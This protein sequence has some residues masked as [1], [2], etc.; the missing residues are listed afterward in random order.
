MRPR[1]KVGEVYG[2]VTVLAEDLIRS[3]PGRTYVRIR[4]E[5]G[6]EKS[7]RYDGLRS[8]LVVSCGCKKREHGYKHGN[9]RSGIYDPLY[10]CWDGMLQ[11]C[12][13]P[14]APHYKDYGGRG[15]TVCEAWLVFE[16]FRA[17]MAPRPTGT[18]LE[19]LNNSQGYSKSN[20]VW[21]THRQQMRNTRRNINITYLNRTQCLTDWCADLGVP[22]S[23][24]QSRITALGWDPVKALITP[25]LRSGK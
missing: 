24:A 2:R 25:N 20:C 14:K 22:Y 4:C 11:R 17:D 9:R 6:K 10:T 16:N 21:A 3:T 15:I 8:G 12:T 18:T 1:D 5:C 7:V 19:R 23:L 13:N